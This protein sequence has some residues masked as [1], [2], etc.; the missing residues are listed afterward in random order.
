[1]LYLRYSTQDVARNTKF[2][3]IFLAYVKLNSEMVDNTEKMMLVS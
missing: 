2:G 1:M 3:F